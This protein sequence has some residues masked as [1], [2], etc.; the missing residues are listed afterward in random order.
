M[1]MNLFRK[2]HSRLL[3]AGLLSMVVGMTAFAQS[4]AFPTYPAGPLG[5]ARGPW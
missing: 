3:L 2:S 5:P 1:Q 4:N